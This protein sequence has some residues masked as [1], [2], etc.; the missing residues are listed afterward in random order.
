M[1][2]D[3]MWIFVLFFIVNIYRI[4]NFK[5]KRNCIILVDHNGNLHQG[6]YEEGND[7]A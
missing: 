4:I 6:K 3:V 7:C 2:Y 1:F 5:Y